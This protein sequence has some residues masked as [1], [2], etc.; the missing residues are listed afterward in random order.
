M[1]SNSNW[2]IDKAFFAVIFTIIA[3]PFWILF[4]P[5][6]IILKTIA[7]I[8]QPYFFKKQ[9][10]EWNKYYQEC[11]KKGIHIDY[12]PSYGTFLGVEPW[13]KKGL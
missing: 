12:P 2:T 11:L 3:I 7:T 13:F 9:S 8:W 10:E 4:G 5:F 1:G 6:Y